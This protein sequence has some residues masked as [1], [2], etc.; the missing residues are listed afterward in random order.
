[1]Q[2]RIIEPSKAGKGGAEYGQL[3]GLR[4]GQK[5]L[6]VNQGAVKVLNAR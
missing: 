3:K 2:E 6:L 5:I 4:K 1:M